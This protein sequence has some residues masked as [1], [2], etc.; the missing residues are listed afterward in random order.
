MR[1]SPTSVEVCRAEGAD[2]AQI[3]ALMRAYHDEDEYPFSPNRALAALGALAR[4]A[5]RLSGRAAAPR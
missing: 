4:R 1:F 2:V 5:A 3:H